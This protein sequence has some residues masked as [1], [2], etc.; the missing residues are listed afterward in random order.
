MV[1]ILLNYVILLNLKLFSGET[2]VA[3]CST[4]FSL[5]GEGDGE[6][7]GAGFGFTTF[8]SIPFL[9]LTFTSG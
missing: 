6:L 7:K 3:T 8:F 4:M 9:S 1:G 5:T 2:L